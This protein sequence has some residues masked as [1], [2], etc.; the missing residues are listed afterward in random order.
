MVPVMRDDQMP[1]LRFSLVDVP[2]DTRFRVML[3]IYDIEPATP[4]SVRV[5]AYA[6]NYP[7]GGGHADTLLTEFTP[8]SHPTDSRSASHQPKS[9][10]PTIR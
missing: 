7:D 3:R 1:P 9:S 2:M 6:E 4:P 10:F 5:R 8:P